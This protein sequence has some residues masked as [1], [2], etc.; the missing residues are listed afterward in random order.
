MRINCAFSD[1]LR[2]AEASVLRQWRDR[3]MSGLYLTF[4]IA[5]RVHQTINPVANRNDDIPFL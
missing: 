4:N 3:A 1:E 2:A 5:G